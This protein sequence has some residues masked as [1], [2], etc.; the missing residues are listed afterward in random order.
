M[1]R[2]LLV[3]ALVVLSAATTLAQTPKVDVF[4]GYS[5]VHSDPNGLEPGNAH[6]WE[7]SL[8]YNWNSWLGLKADFDG[9]YCCDQSMYNFLFG[10]QINLGHGKLTPYLEGLV[11]ASHG[12]SAGTFSDTVL[13]FAVGGGADWKLTHRLSWRV[14]QA[15]L[16]GT[17]YNDVTQKNF[18]FST[19][20]VFHFGKR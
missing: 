13:G 15:D 18:R 6:G 10:P 5:F 4:G 16:L 19:G 2:T 20:L 11:G 12:N 3:T 8:A 14:A 9:H 17:R 1:N 7:A